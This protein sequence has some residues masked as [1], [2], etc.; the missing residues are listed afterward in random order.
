MGMRFRRSIGWGPL[1]FTLTPKGISKSIGVGPFRLTKRSDGK[2]QTTTRIPGTGLSY[3]ATTKTQRAAPKTVVPEPVFA[4][5]LTDQE[6]ARARKVRNVLLNVLL[7]IGG[8]LL[9]AFLFGR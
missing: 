6:K 8:I 1:R 7:V 2:L 5:A 3:T 4:R 9:L